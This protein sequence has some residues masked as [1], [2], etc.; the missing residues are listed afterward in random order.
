MKRKTTGT[1]CIVLKECVDRREMAVVCRWRKRY[2]ARLRERTSN[3]PYDGQTDD[4]RTLK[5][6]VSPENHFSAN[7]PLQNK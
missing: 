7:A 4:V 5:R 2:R 6:E 1:E 3:V